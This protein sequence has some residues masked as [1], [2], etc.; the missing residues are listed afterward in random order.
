MKTG[1]LKT[2]TAALRQVG[3]T[4]SIALGLTLAATTIAPI[5]PAHAAACDIDTP[6][7]QMTYEGAQSV[8]ECLKDDLYAN[9]NKGNKR[10]IPAEFVKDYR[11][12][13]LASTLPADP[14]FHG[15]RYLL[16]F[17]NETGYD[18]YTR[19]ADDG[20][21]DMPAGSVIAKESFS[22]TDKGKVKPGP[23][24][25]MQRVAEGKSPK[26]DDWY[27]MMVMPNGAPAAVNVYS[28]CSD[29]HIGFAHQGNLGYPVPEARVGQ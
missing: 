13:E 6:R 12:W 19:F 15:G 10:W 28:A 24:F 21:T 16:T 11:D 17:V 20:S 9:Y 27:Y 3:I 5:P 14:G 2:S 29:C 25:L 4:A 1:F 8:W 22:I 18:E 23:L 26:T 7:D